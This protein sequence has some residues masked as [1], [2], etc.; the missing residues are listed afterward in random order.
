MIVGLN[1]N[2]VDGLGRADWS[3]WEEVGTFWCGA[4]LC[5]CCTDEMIIDDGEAG[6]L[7]CFCKGSIIEWFWS[8]VCVCEGGVAGKEFDCEERSDCSGSG[9]NRSGKSDEGTVV[10]GCCDRAFAHWNCWAYKNWSGDVGGTVNGWID[11]VDDGTVDGWSD[12]AAV[13]SRFVNRQ[14]W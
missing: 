2:V 10:S 11:D 8:P 7:G 4:L 12:G 9:C 6:A 13:V 5:C 3:C 1:W 14:F